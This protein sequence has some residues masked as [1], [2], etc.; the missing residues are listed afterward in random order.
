M[1][2]PIL[3]VIVPVYNTRLYLEQCLHSLAIQTLT[4]IEIIMV[5]DGS[6]D[7]S[8]EL[9]KKQAIADSRFRYVE[10]MNGGLSVA[11][12]TGMRLAQGIYI[13]F[14]DSDDWFLTDDCLERICRMAERKEADIIAGNT[15]SVYS[16]GR[17]ELWGKNCK[18]TFKYGE[19]LNG[20]EFFVHMKEQGCY[21]PMVSNYVYRRNFLQKHEFLF[22]PGVIHED[23]LWTPQVLTSARRVVYMDVSHYGYRQREGSIMTA[24]SAE[25]RIA[26]L[27]IIVDKLLEYAD[28]YTNT[29]ADAELVKNAIEMNVLRLYWIAC[30][31]RQ[32]GMHTTLFDKAGKILSV[33]EKASSGQY[34]KG[35]YRKYI[36]L[37]MKDFYNELQ[38]MTVL[39]TNSRYN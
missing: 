38:E 2:K 33:C 11:R 13:A 25:R 7:G 34:A 22:E 10:Q 5:N 3:S 26:S 4:D 14:L 29:E 30:S 23:E 8:D 6:T 31:I 12:N 37:S 32:K 17:R 24:T 1:S 9:L 20:G 16:D 18:E 28:K 36:L 21:V 27:Q 15:W 19:A 39:L 35:E